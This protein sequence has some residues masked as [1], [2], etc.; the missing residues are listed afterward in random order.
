MQWA[1]GSQHTVS[2]PAVVGPAVGTRY[3]FTQWSD[4]VT[5]KR[6]S[7]TAG[8]VTTFVA[9]YRQQF[10]VTLAASPV[11]GGVV[12]G[13]GWYTA[14]KDATLSATAANGFTF[15]AF[16]GTLGGTSEPADCVRDAAAELGGEFRAGH[17]GSDGERRSAHQH[18]RDQHGADAGGRQHGSGR[19]LAHFHPFD[20]DGGANGSGTV[21]V[22]ATLPS[23]GML[24]PGQSV[25]LMCR[26]L[27]VHRH[28][29]RLHGDRRRQWRH[30]CEQVDFL[31][32]R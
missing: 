31:C 24:L 28:E 26:C 14:G 32:G 10:Q 3:V 8:A 17:A 6:R 23:P 1:L 19:G 20:L 4:G 9:R 25:S 11:G 5:T 2:V 27:A 12:A 15:S 22:P 18:Q 7:I 29:G 16:S 21:V 13:A 30:I